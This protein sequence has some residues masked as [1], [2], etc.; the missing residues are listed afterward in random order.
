M[1]NFTKLKYHSIFLLTLFLSMDVLAQ[2]ARFSQFYNAPA[3]VNPALAGTFNGDYR[4]SAQYRDQ[5]S[6]ILG[7]QPYRTFSAGLEKRFALGADDSFTLG[8]Y[9]LR[10][11]RIGAGALTQN[12]VKLNASFMKQLSG[13]RYSAEHFLVAGAQLGGGQNQLKG[14]ALWF[15]EQYNGSNGQVDLTADNGEAAI[16]GELTSNLFA[17]FN[18]GLLWYAVFDENRSLYAGAA[19]F[20]LNR[21]NISL[22]NDR[23]EPLYR[24]LVLQAGGELPFSSNLSLLPAAVFMSQGPSTSITLG[25]NVRYSNHDWNEVAI[26]A[27][28]W[29]HLSN[30]LESNL[31]NDAW[32]FALIL[33]V[34]RWNIGLSY[35]L[36]ASELEKATNHRGAFELSVTYTH[37]AKRRYK[38]ACP[39][40]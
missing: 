32:I 18:A 20:H 22:L 19:I 12:R 29:S 11:D 34:E 6:S 25:A 37:P 9:G 5:W 31:V 39:N 21:P 10:D 26:R 8:I 38:L 36:N 33:E 40:F 35:E 13:G 17:D 1:L 23:E 3:L 14:D 16:N 15:S 7:S 27:G 2:D 28:L 30:G 4:F 24:R